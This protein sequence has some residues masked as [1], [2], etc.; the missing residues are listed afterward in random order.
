[1]A[2]IRAGE[3]VLLSTAS[4]ARA[5]PDRPPKISGALGTRQ[6]L[7]GPPVTFATERSVRGRTVGRP[8]TV[9]CRLR[10]CRPPSTL[11]RPPRPCLRR[12][13][14]VAVWTLPPGSFVAALR[15]FLSVSPVLPR[16]LAPVVAFPP[17]ILRFAPV[18]LRPLCR[19]LPVTPMRL[20]LLRTPT[21]TRRLTRSLARTRRSRSIRSPILVA[22]PLPA[23]RAAR[24][25]VL[26]RRHRPAARRA[27]PVSFAM[28]V[29][30]ARLAMLIH[31]SLV[32]RCSVR[33][34]RTFIASA[35]QAVTASAR[36]ILTV[37]IV[38]SVTIILRMR[39]SSTVAVRA[40]AV[41]V[42][43]VFRASIPP[44][45]SAATAH[46][47]AFSRFSIWV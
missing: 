3:M 20:A 27:S 36:R 42:I 12:A 43:P 25:R 45:F 17:A 34:L 41:P 26:H 16:V 31:R 6:E 13:A 29:T 9:V 46:A 24:T 22:L 7:L 19:R 44:V 39:C 47:R 15:G 8:A 14:L 30:S 35:A 23:V 1:M 11:T 28:I 2:L 32:I 4:L 33:L 38:R 5:S 10:P 40:Q 21:P 37:R 18:P